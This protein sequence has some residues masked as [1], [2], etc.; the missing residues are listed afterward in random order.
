[1]ASVDKLPDGRGYKVRWREGKRARSKTVA[2]FA[3]ARTLRA[4]IEGGEAQPAPSSAAP[5]WEVVIVAYLAELAISARPVTVE[6]RAIQLARFGRWA[7]A[8]GIVSPCELR[9]AAITRFHTWLS[10]TP[11][12]RWRPR[13]ASTIK[14]AM[15]SVELFAVWLT[16]A[17]VD[18][19]WPTPIGVRRIRLPSVVSDMV[20]AAQL[21]EVEAMISALGARKIAAPSLAAQA[22]Y[23]LAVVQRWTGARIGEVM[24]ATWRDVDLVTGDWRIP[25]SKTGMGRMVP[26]PSEL[27]AALMS[28]R[29]DPDAPLLGHTFT[30]GSLIKRFLQAWAESGTDAEVYT[31]RPTHA[32]R[33]AVRSHLAAHSVPDELVNVLLGHGRGVAGRYEDTRAV[34][35]R[36]VA[37]VELLGT[38]VS[39]AVSRE[40]TT[41]G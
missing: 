34:W 22:A 28:W 37:A 25:T 40:G 35:P 15:Q 36:L 38:P 19:G 13:T 17:A 31:Q 9:T 1:M 14:A 39:W 27:R 20:R 2:S 11:S 32:I 29:G 24:A 7:E 21:Y 30:T 4:A 18:F 8:E 41:G 10:T 5:S 16:G 3:E 6:T 12:A 26:L 33:R 23:R